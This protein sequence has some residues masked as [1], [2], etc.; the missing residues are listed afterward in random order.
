MTRSAAVGRPFGPE[1]SS[2]R[3]TNTLVSCA[4][5]AVARFD[6]K[7]SS[8]PSGEKIGKPSKPGLCVM[9]SKSVP[10]T[11]TAYKSNSRPFGSPTLLENKTRLPDGKKNGANE[12]AFRY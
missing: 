6:E 12:A 3:A 5:G 1:A 11:L 9:R 7:A 2:Q 4:P 8:L 10:S